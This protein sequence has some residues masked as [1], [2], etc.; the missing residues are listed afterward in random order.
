M[1]ILIF[2]IFKFIFGEINN[3][4]TLSL[5]LLILLIIFIDI[6]MIKYIYDKLSFI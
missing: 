6:S 2:S 4:F 5:V 1:I 3:S